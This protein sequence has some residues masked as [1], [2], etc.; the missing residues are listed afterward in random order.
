M[1]LMQRCNIIEELWR[2]RGI[3]N[4]SN[5]DYKMDQAKQVWWQHLEVGWTGVSALVTPQWPIVTFSG[6][7]ETVWG[8]W[9]VG[10]Q[11]SLPSSDPQ[12]TPQWPS[13]SQVKLSG[14]RWGGISAISILRLH[15]FFPWQAGRGKRNTESNKKKL[16]HRNLR[17]ARAGEQNGF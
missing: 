15:S 9:V 1:K 16:L 12:M 10:L 7:G 3:W 14:E 17:K 8:R 4:Q 13:N 11:A 5:G 6:L 2:K